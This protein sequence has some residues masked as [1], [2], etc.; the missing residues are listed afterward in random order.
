MKQSCT[1]GGSGIMHPISRILKHPLRIAVLVIGCLMQMLVAYGQTTQ[2]ETYRLSGKVSSTTGEALP[3]V[4]VLVK[5]TQTGT[6]T[7]VDGNFALNVSSDDVILVSFIGYLTQEV[8]V[9]GKTNISVSL[10]EDIAQLDEVVVVGYGEMKR[11]EI[12]GAQTSIGSEEIQKTVNT[13][14]EQA[15]QG[16]AAG[17]YVTQNTGQPGGGISVNIRGVNSINGS[18][19]P[20]YVIDGVQIAPPRVE[21]GAASSSNPLAGLNPADIES[22]EILQGPSATAI[23]GSRGTN[24]VIL[25]TTKRGKA[26]MMTINYEFLYS[27]QDKPEQ[28]PVMNLSQYAQMT[29]EYHEIAGGDSPGAFLDPSILGEG[30]NWQDE[31]FRQAPLMKHQ[32]SLSGGSDKTTFY[33]SGEYFDQEGVALGSSFDRYSLRLNVDNQTRDWLK[34]GANLNVSQ[35]DELIGTTQDN[36]I[37]NALTLAPNIPVQNPDGSW[38]GADA[39]NGSSVQFTPL[40]PVAIANLNQNDRLRRQFLGGISAEAKIFEGLVFRTNL[41]TNVSYGNLTYFQPTWQIGDKLNETAILTETNQMNSSWNWNQLLEYSKSFGRHNLTLMASHESQASYWENLSGE[42]RGFVTNEIP[43]LNIG[44][45]QGATNGGGKGDWAMESYFGRINYNFEEKYILQGAVRADGSS[46]FGPE[47]RWG[48]FPSLSAAWRISEESFMDGVSL[49]NEL[50]LR[51]E[52][53]VTGNQGSGGIFSPLR[54]VT[55]PWG[56]GFIAERYGNPNLQWEETTT[57]NIGFN[58]AMLENRIQLEG[59]FYIKQ[60]DNLLMNN[61]LPDY[62]G[63]AG[64]GSIGTP[65]VNIGALENKGYAIT[66]STVNIDRGSFTWKSNFNISGFKTK[67]TEF[68]SEAAFVDRTAWFM[69]N[70]T[71]RATVGETPWLFRGYVYDGLFTS[72]EEIENSALPTNSEGGELAIGENSV[73][74]GDIKY[75]DI[76]EDGVIDERDQTYIGNPWPKFS[77][78]FTNTFNYRG[79]DL[80]V[81]LTGSYGNDIYNYLR[82]SNTDPNNINLGR[83]MLAE[84]Y[85]YARVALDESG[86]PYLEN[87]G[88]D[89]PRISSTNVNGNAE[90][91]TDKFVEDGSY[92]R[93]K[94]VQLSYNFPSGLLSQQNVIQGLRLSAGVQNLYTFTKYKGYDPEV[95]AYVGRDVDPNNQAIG[96]DFGRY[97]LTPVY[98]FSVGVNF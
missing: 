76:N 75:K 27:L 14:I 28:L 81:L 44:S 34:L 15:I 58:L 8:P 46:N 72:L 57:N 70:W 89:I 47:N 18:N 60:T 90:R 39:L 82:F 59:D 25:I 67:I 20:L 19:E 88:T 85:D 61:P 74:V 24:G 79:F 6:V 91:F 17:V 69:D 42:R 80:T 38:G 21:Y 37:N 84:T 30:T 51:V 92:I 36:L 41:N 48:I 22:M 45:L 13:T 11:A 3:G 78:G 2:N 32:L 68:Y 29:N 62:M 23:Y 98:T 54:S 63:T 55:T 49:I 50:K 65:T 83:N 7:D 77:F 10:E 26:G 73:W 33:L 16:R 93:V 5:G 71:Q 87:P 52:T 95:G 4:N 96:V 35:T 43:D 40:N 12:S 53:G 97:P 86:N 31:L 9:N 64:E 66:L 1:G 94:N 56:A